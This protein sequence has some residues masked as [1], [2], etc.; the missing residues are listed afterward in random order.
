[1]S[2]GRTLAE[3]TPRPPERAVTRL[4]LDGLGCVMAAVREGAAGPAI[5]VARAFGGVPEA[6]VLPGPLRLPAP[7]AA[8]AN[9]ALAHALDF[10]DTHAGGLVHPTAVVLPV[11]FSVGEETGASGAE[12]VAAAGAGIETICRLAAAVPHGFHARGLHATSVCGVFG[13][14][15]TAARLYRLDADRTVHALGIAGS[16]AA[17]L[18]EFLRS[19]GTVKQVHTGF[20]AQDGVLS[21]RLAEAGLTGPERILDGEYGLYRALLGETPAATAILDGL[22]ERWEL[23]QVSVKPYPACRLLHAALDAAVLVRPSVDPAAVERIEVTLH[24]DAVP[25]VCGEPPVTPYD[26]KFS[27]AWS[28]A[29]LLLDG[30]LDYSVIDRPEVR[31]L[32]GRIV[33]VP[34]GSPG[35]AADQPARITVRQT[36]GAVRQRTVPRASGAPGDPRVERIIRTKASLGPVADLVL[37]LASLPSLSPVLT[38]LE[39]HQ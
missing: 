12:I 35:P 36:G 5:T 11:A 37:D 34:V 33:A 3:W 22:G 18:L 32:A 38:A 15:L 10:D 28:V 19:G 30:T 20:A 8:F 23:E 29:A 4:L 26:A 31:A 2:V 24:P 39:V 27:L 7:A 1:M 21:A 6:T 13:A 25:I 16:R 17:G 9:G 14:A